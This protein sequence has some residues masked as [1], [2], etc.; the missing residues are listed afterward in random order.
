MRRVSW[1]IPNI[2]CPACVMHLEALEDELD[3][4][5]FIQGNYKK[6]RLEVAFDEA[7]VSEAEIRA[8]V[9]ELGYGIAEQKS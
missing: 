7:V 1:T 2:H 4:I 9:N 8:A 5:E 6:Q 3:G